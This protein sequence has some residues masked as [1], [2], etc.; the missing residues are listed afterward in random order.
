MKW[1]ILIC[2]FVMASCTK[3]KCSDAFVKDYNAMGSAFQ[4]LYKE[5]A[6]QDELNAFR[7]SM[8]AFI[9]AHKDVKCKIDKEEVNP[10]TEV[11]ATISELD[12]VMKLIAKV[13][14]GQDNRVDVVDSPVSR[15]R[16]WADSTAAHIPLSELD[17]N[18]NIKSESLGS[19]IGLCPGERFYNQF[20]AARCSGFLVGTDTIVTAGHCMQYTSDCSDI[21]WA[22]GYYKG[23]TQLKADDVYTCKKVIKQVVNSNGLDYAVVQLDRPVVGRKFFRYRT[24]GKISDSANL[25]VIGYPSGL[26]AKIADGASVRDN[27]NSYWFSSNLDTFGGNS[28]SAVID[29]SSGLVEGI[30]VR[31]ETDYV[32]S[33]VNGSS[34]YKVNVC[35]N[36]GCGGEE[37]TRMTKVEGIPTTLDT[38]SIMIGLFESQS[39]P[40]VES[41]AKV[42]TLGY[43]YNGYTVAG[44][45]F[46]KVCGSHVYKDGQPKWLAS[47]SGSC[48]SQKSVIDEFLR[49]IQ[50]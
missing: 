11:L 7:N 2:L 44:R 24:S 12:E 28:G 45:K 10:T 34:C 43:S 29:S 32:V 41:G 25:V 20:S 3:D 9:S 38:N 50:L 15:Y 1:F 37:V 21:V 36:N 39:L 35:P 8:N 17:S 14:Y 22:F 5:G 16:E 30:L 18:Y 31:G 4:N 33:S 47:G 48:E 26:P 6:T 46:L 13:V 49:L 19:A 23:V 40:T 42:K 27:E